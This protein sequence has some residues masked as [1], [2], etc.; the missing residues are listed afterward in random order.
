MKHIEVK[1]GREPA[2]TMQMAQLNLWHNEHPSR[3][4]YKGLHSPEWVVSTDIRAYLKCGTAGD[5]TIRTE[6]QQHEGNPAT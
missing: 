2:V 5:E 3:H 1:G 4:Y 6:I